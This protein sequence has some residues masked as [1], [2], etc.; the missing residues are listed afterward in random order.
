MNN[1][2]PTDL[3][4]AEISPIFKKNDRLNKINYRPISILIILSKVYE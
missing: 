2:F 3:K 1:V 4:M